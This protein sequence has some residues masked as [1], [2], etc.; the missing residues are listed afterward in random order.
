MFRNLLVAKNLCSQCKGPGFNPSSGKWIP[1]RTL[2]AATTKISPATAKT[3]YSQKKKKSRERE[4]KCLWSQFSLHGSYILWSHCKYWIIASWWMKVSE[5]RLWKP[6]AITV[7]LTEQQI[8]LLYMCF[9]FRT[10]YLTHIVDSLVLNSWKTTRYL[11]NDWNLTNT[12]ISHKTHCSLL[13]ARNTGQNFSTGLWGHFK[14]K[15]CQ[16]IE[17]KKKKCRKCGTK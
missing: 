10:P 12:P 11:M 15:N 4:K 13:A 9:Y 7:F 1:L 5:E 8:I 14:W 16:E 3:G 6:L 2:H 17:K